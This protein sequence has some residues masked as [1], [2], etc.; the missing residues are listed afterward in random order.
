MEKWT[1]RRTIKAGTQQRMIKENNRNINEALSNDI[2]TFKLS[3]GKQE[4]EKADIAEMLRSA[5]KIVIEIDKETFKEKENKRKPKWQKKSSTT[6]NKQITRTQRKLNKAKNTHKKRDNTTKYLSQ[7]HDTTPQKSQTELT[8]AQKNPEAHYPTDTNPHT[9]I[10]LDEGTSGD[11]THH[12]GA[13]ATSDDGE[14][15][16]R[17]EDFTTPQTKSKT[18]TE[19]TPPPPPPPTHTHTHTNTHTI[20]PKTCPQ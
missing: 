18:D 13:E 7:E 6:N 5:E 20:D 16:S 2:P 8:S 15:E 19:N 1:K 14:E 12:Y 17:A 4:E 11:E 10:T 3:K 9:Q